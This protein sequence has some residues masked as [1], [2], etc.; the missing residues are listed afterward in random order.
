MIKHET[1][2]LDAPPT[3]SNLNSNSTESKNK[4][5]QETDEDCKLQQTASPVPSH[6]GT[7]LTLSHPLLPSGQ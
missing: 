3:I 6:P 5:M 2:F 1:H 7:T 4:K